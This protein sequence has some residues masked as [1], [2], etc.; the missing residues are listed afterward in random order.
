MSEIAI[1]PARESDAEFLGWVILTA[2]RGHLARGWFDVVLRRDET[3]GL[4]FCRRL[5]AARARSWWHWSL[6]TI[7]EVDGAPASALCGFGDESVYG[8]SSAAMAEASGGMDVS[9]DEKAQYWPRGSFI[10]SC[11]T[12]EEG[13]WTI[14][15]VATLPAY[16]GRGLLQALLVNEFARAHAEG[17]ARAQISFLIGNDPAERAYA[18]AGFVF[19]E[20]ATSPEFEKALGVPGL[21]RLARDI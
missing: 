3:F 10:L 20:E 14:E 2:A 6:F 13:A 8:A 9:A 19:A 5:V 7:V 15:N 18:R 1:R 16:R 4:E 17:Y 12:G 21:R 11:T